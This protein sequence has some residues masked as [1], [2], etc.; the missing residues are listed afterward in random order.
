MRRNLIKLLRKLEKESSYKNDYIEFI[1]NYMCNYDVGEL[2]NFP[3]YRYVIKKYNELYGETPENGIKAELKRMEADSL[4]MIEIQNAIKC[5]TTKSGSGPDFDEGIEFKTESIILTTKGK[6]NWR[7]V[8]HMA[9]ENPI[10]TTLSF[11]AIIISII[12]LFI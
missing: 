4:V 12:A 5:L 10:T 3:D 9:M 8:L 7:Y 2:L 11:L 6:S 1:E